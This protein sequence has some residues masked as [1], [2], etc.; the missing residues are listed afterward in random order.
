[1]KQ[2]PHAS[3]LTSIWSFMTREFDQP[4]KEAMQMAAELQ[5]AGAAS[6]QERGWHAINWQTANQEVKR[7]Q[8]RIVKAQQQG[9]WGR[10][11]ALQHLLTHSFSGKALAVKRVT[12]NQGKRTPGVDG[13]IWKTPQKKAE[14][15]E[16]LTQRGYHP[17]PL[18]R[19]YIPKS[20]G[21]QRP[22]SIPTMK[23]RAMQALY[24]LALDP[25]AE[26]LADPNSYGFRK[27]RSTA[28]AIDQCHT[29]LSNRAGAEWI[30]EGDIKACFDKISH[31]WL[32]AYIP[33]EKSILRKWLKAGF[34][35]KRVLKPTEEGTPQGGICSPV[36]ANLALDGLEA[37]LREKYPKASNASRKAKA[38][39]VRFADDFIITGSSKELLEK[40]IKPLVEQFM[41]ERGLGLSQEK[42][43][44]THITTGFDFLGQNIRKYQDGKVLVKPS[45]MNVK[46]FL[47]KLRKLIKENAQ[48]TAGNL[49]MQLNPKIRGWAN[50]HRHVSS[51]QTFVKVDD[52]IFR[53]LWQWAKRRHPKKPGR[54]VKDKYFH[55][56][57]QRNWV[58]CGE[59]E[60]PDGTTRNVQL[61]YAHTVPIERHT[62][63]KGDANPYDPA[64]EMYFEERLGV[65]M[66]HNLKGKRQLIY[67]W[68]EQNGLCPVCHQKI[69]KLTGWNNHHIVRR[70]DGGADRRE[71]RV[72]LHPNCHRQVHS[73]G[74]SVVKP[75]PA[76]G[77]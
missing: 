42:T 1:M 40:E 35:E 30:L 22:L 28:D 21:S 9:K 66:V 54:W 23:D 47:A 31:A 17:R 73:Q 6:H 55:S 69:T 63:I 11:K 8:V 57:G 67:L 15:I 41:K 75:R 50:Y 60:E 71:N 27:E 43:H 49:I 53:A 77:R 33:M 16:T 51:K 13:E 48:A 58:F 2:T 74:L 45:K 76:K 44:I 4:T 38:N 18:R 19:I 14:A 39:L 72:L 5:S 25:I 52:A 10:V 20:N 65:K 26:I 37:K 34:I 62:K 36:I 29:V 56:I 7:L 32:E 12:E 59:I 64:W 61:F 68:K 3:G 70:V 46:N 24:L